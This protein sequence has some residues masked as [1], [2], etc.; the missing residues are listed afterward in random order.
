MTMDT[1]QAVQY[2]D[3][4]IG[5][6]LRI[7]TTDSRMFVGIF[8]CTDAHEITY[9]DHGLTGAI[10][11]ERNVILANSFEYRLPTPSAVQAAADSW[12][13]NSG[14][15]SATIKVNMTHRLIGLIVVPGRHITKIELE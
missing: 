7:H 15:Q 2:L 5:R 6:Q 4:L 13:K 10:L 1:E 3:R 9:Q 14:A 8:K 11:Q 12:E